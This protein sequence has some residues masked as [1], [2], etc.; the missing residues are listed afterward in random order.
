MRHLTHDRQMACMHICQVALITCKRKR[1]KSV[2]TIQCQTLGLLYFES[3][4][5]CTVSC[6]LVLGALLLMS[7]NHDSL[8]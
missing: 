7:F 3:L 8:A 1:L 4:E 2:W 6:I 5:I